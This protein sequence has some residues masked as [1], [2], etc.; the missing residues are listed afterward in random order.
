MRSVMFAELAGA[1]N[2]AAL[3]D[4]R[5][6]MDQPAEAITSDDLDIGLGGVGKRAQLRGVA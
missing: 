1:R 2:L 3:C 4:L 6:F 5:V